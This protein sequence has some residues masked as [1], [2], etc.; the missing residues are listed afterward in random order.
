MSFP[1][2]E[3]DEMIQRW[4]QAN[5]E[6]EQAGDWRPLAEFYTEDATYGWNYGPKHDFMAIGRTEIRDY[7]IGL[8]MDG[9]DGWTYPYQAWVTDEKTGDML[10]LWKQVCEVKR[11]DGTNYA[12][13]GIQGSWFKYGGDFQWKWQRD[14]F[15]YGNLTALFTEMITNDDLPAGVNKRIERVVNSKGKLPGWYR[16]GTSPVPLW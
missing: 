3:L 16:L 12:L 5:I 11:A 1:R 2:A 13:D 10:G 6:C 9:L 8:E 4:L 7:A 15:D 14:F